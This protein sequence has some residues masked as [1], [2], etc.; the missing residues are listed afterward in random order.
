MIQKQDI[1]ISQWFQRQGWKPFP[2]QEQTW[3]AYG[4]GK[5]GLLNAPTGSGK[6]YA[7]WVPMVRDILQQHPTGTLPKGLKAI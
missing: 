2:F 5:H 6:T 1:Q 7:L 3:K 4:Q